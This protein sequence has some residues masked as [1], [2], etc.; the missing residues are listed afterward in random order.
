MAESNSP[1]ATATALGTYSSAVYQTYHDPES[2]DELVH[3]VLDALEAASGRP[4]ADMSVR[5]YDSVDPD[6]LNDIFRPTR[7]GASRDEGRVR[8]TVGRYAVTVAASGH[9][10]VRPTS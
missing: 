9:V 1:I 6:A 2:G 10:F 8:F 3:T 4:A 5:L 7:G